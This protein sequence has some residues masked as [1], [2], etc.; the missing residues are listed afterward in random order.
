[1]EAKLKNAR[2]ELSS[3]SEDAENKFSKLEGAL[4]EELGLSLSPSTNN[5]LREDM[6]MSN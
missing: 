2:G 3:A 5:G 4:D 6:Q 1:M